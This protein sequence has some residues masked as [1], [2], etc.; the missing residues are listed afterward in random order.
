[1]NKVAYSGR[2]EDSRGRKKQGIEKFQKPP[3]TPRFLCFVDYS[4]F[5]ELNYEKAA[6]K[7]QTRVWVLQQGGCFLLSHALARAIFFKISSVYRL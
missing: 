1:M 4:N 7:G 3:A 2:M 6:R 5:V